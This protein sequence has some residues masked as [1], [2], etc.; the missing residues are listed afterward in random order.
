MEVDRPLQSACIAIQEN[1]DAAEAR[2]TAAAL[3][4]NLSFNETSA[5]NLALVVTEAAKNVL[6]HAGGGQIILRGLQYGDG[7]E[8][9]A[10]DKGPGIPDLVR[11]V[12]DGYSTA[13]TP[14]SDHAPV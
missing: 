6:K 9:L 13:G 2:R 8:M 14:G 1:T 7:I 12:Q 4:S 5:G 11:C 10:L 3:A